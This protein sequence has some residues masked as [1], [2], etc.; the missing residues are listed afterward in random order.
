MTVGWGLT[1]GVG[2]RETMH[3]PST[4]NYVAGDGK[5]FWVVG[6]E[7]ERHWPPMARVVG[8]PEWID[9][10]RWATSMDR[11]INGRE[12][13]AE[14]DKVFVTRTLPEWIEVF[15]TEPDFFWAPLNSPDDLL[16]D[17]QFQASGALIDVPDGAS[18]TTMIA[19]PCDFHGTPGAARSL[20]PKLGEHTAEVLEALGRGAE[21]EALAATGAVGVA[22]PD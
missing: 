12:L 20:A 22:P 7:A 5:R 10:P 18:T 8:H 19:T 21:V 1:L 13:I 6:L 14:L 3:N 4:N 17:P 16:V 9:D 2:R 11:A 15:D